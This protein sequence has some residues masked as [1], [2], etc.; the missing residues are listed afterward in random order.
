[1]IL[2]NKDVSVFPE[3]RKKQRRK[4]EITFRS[5]VVHEQQNKTNKSESIKR[6]T[7]RVGFILSELA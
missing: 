6:H 2:E 7:V 4:R 1:M 3:M 5:L